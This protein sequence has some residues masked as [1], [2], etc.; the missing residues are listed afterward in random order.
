M[1]FNSLPSL[2]MF[3]GNA[4]SAM[5]T[6]ELNGYLERTGGGRFFA[7]NLSQDVQ[8][9]LNAFYAQVLQPQITTMYELASTMGVN[10]LSDFRWINSMEELERGIPLS[11]QIPILTHEP[12][13]RMFE[14]GKLQG[15][16][17]HPCDLPEEDIYGRLIN[18][19]RVD[20]S[21]PP[22]EDG[23]YYLHY[24]WFLDDPDWTYDDIMMV[25][26]SRDWLTDFMNQTKF[27]I[28]DYP[29]KIR[30]MK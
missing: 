4:G 3:T 2:G 13:R 20:L 9:H 10:P 25:R 17:L 18:N 16:S 12:I 11:M 27:D 15:F 22:A 8:S 5:V 1:T 7:Q 14:E 24:K 19:G 28:T 30:R 29:N 26:E 23:N 21:G 6:A